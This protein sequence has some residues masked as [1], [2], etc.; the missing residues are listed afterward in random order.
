[1]NNKKIIE[2]LKDKYNPTTILLHGSRA[3]GNEHK[4]SDWDFIFLYETKDNPGSFRELVEGQNIEVQSV[5]LPVENILDT[6]DTKLQHARVVF[7]TESEGADLVAKAKELYSKGFEWTKTWPIGPKLWMR[8]RVD[9]MKDS[10][11]S[12][13]VFL[14]Y[15]SQFY[16]RA[17]NYWYFVLHKEYSQPVYIALPDI[18]KR[19]PKYR[20]LLKEISDLSKSNEERVSVAEDIMTH[21]FDSK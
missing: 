20:N 6:F 13:E 14:R 3:S 15:F 7:E 17:L 18:E 5:I 4:G 21:L 8:G 16:I 1:M 2:I 11:D 10:V 9:G 12:P 19:D